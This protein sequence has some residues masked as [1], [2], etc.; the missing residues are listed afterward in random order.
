L[1]GGDN[2]ARPGGW[3]LAATLWLLAATKLVADSAV[4]PGIRVRAQARLERSSMT[5]RTELLPALSLRRGRSLRGW[6]PVPS[7]R[8]VRGGSER[9]GAKLYSVCQPKAFK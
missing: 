7:R 2:G 5:S 4:A 3:G 9:D 1:V 8:A 6:R